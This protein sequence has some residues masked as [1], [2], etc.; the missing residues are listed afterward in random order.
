MHL[1]MH[2]ILGN[3]SHDLSLRDA[4]GY[5]MHLAMHDILGNPSHD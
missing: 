5:I 4:R 1:T 3:P 2:D